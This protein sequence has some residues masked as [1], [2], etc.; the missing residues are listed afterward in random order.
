MAADLQRRRVLLCVGPGGVGK[1]TCAAALALAAARQGRKVAV[2]TV[3]P[4]RRLA[5]ALGVEA[6]GEDGE[7]VEVA[8]AGAGGG[9]LHASV[10]SPRRVFDHIVE[11]CS[12]D[13]ESADR[14]LGNSIYRATVQHLGG[15][16]EYAAMARVH[17]LHTDGR[18][19]LV[20]LDTP[21][22][23]NAMAFL[24]A[25]ARVREVVSNPAARLLAGTGKIGMK[26]LGLGGGVLLKGL[27][28]I[29]GGAF[30]RAL[31]EF[32]R[33]FAEVLREFQHRA[34]DF[35]ALLHAPDTGVILTTTPAQFSVREAIDFLSVLRSHGLRLDGVALN[36]VFP[37]LP[38]GPS[39]E[40]LDAALGADEAARLA[41]LYE[42]LRKEGARGPAAVAEIQA[43]HPR[44]AVV[45]LGLRD[46]PPTSLEE[47]REMGDELLVEDGG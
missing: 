5:Q 35:D 44:L 39:R 40:D 22:T 29:G 26:I 9:S 12:R 23:A 21:P 32:L 4:S 13:R 6:H 37:E 27:E 16:L 36:R 1:T 10:L 43:A 41:A 24:Q 15:A 45:R 7:I 34:G 30:L 20:V 38:E 3:D 25:P 11:A 28:S 46:S 42:G 8:G 17:M 2:V 47:L 18:W 33:D 19:D 14:V 31:G